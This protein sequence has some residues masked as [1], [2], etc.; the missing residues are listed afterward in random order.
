[1]SRAADSIQSHITIAGS[2]TSRPS[3]GP[4]ECWVCRAREKAPPK[5]GLELSRPGPPCLFRGQMTAPT[6]GDDCFCSAGPE[7]TPA[8]IR[9]LG[10]A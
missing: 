8:L 10:L 2:P 1:M 4:H 3:L 5:P 7:P 9:L 6:A